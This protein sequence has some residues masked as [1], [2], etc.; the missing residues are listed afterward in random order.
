MFRTRSHIHSW[1]KEYVNSMQ[2]CFS[3]IL[4]IQACTK[5][6]KN[7]IPISNNIWKTSNILNIK[8]TVT[9]VLHSS[10]KSTYLHTSTYSWDR[11]TQLEFVWHV[12]SGIT[13]W[14]MMKCNMSWL[15]AGYSANVHWNNVFIHC[16]TNH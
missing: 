6:R 7:I 2:I 12:L 14:R 11:V 4:C 13:W 10:S 15:D 5:L 3:A 16:R 9:S 8:F 1:T